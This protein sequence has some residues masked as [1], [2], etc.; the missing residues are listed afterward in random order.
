MRAALI[1]RTLFVA[2]AL[3]LAGAG[4]SQACIGLG[5]T[6]GVTAD[7]VAFGTY[8][9]FASAP[10]D[11]ST[12]LVSVNCGAQVAVFFSY[13]VKFSIGG[14]ATYATRRMVSGA[15]Q[16]SYQLY[17]D[18]GRTLIW[19]NGAAGS[20]YISNSYTL[21]VNLLSRSD[22]FPIYA[23][24]PAHQNVKPGDYSDSITVTITF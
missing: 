18:S 23:R 7:N 16:L 11:I 21:S 17:T 13:D 4:A 9:P 3:W 10:K 5:C 6:C 19:G 14:A 1:A 8:D 22:T 15:N 12:S 20:S 24:L 2:G